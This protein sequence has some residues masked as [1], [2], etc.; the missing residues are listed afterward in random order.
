M[1]VNGYQWCQWGSMVFT[2]YQRVLLGIDASMVFHSTVFE[3]YLKMGCKQW[4]STGYI[5]RKTIGVCLK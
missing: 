4:I 2:G 3:D 1:G 5:T